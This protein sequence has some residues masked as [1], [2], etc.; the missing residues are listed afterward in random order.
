MFFLAVG[1]ITVRVDNFVFVV[2]PADDD[3]SPKN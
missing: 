3:V 2:E 1:G